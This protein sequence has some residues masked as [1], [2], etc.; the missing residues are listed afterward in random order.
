MK[1]FTL[2]L[3]LTILFSSASF[4]QKGSSYEKAMYYLKEKGEVIFTF[5]ANSKAQFLEINRIVSVSHK[6]V[7]ENELKA[8]VYA[9]KE[10]FQKFLTYGLA[11]EVTAE[12][13]EIPQELTA[14][15]AAAAWDTTWDA[16]P[17]YSE[18]VAKMQ[19]WAATYPSLCT[20]QSIGT[21]ALGRTL[22]VLKISD[23]AST[24]E[25]EPEF[26]YTSSMH[27]DEITGYPTMLH[28]I[29]YLLTNYGSL[30]EI[31][32]LVN[33]T[34]LYINPLANPDG[35]YKTISND[36]YNPG[37]ATNTPTR[38]NSLGVDLNRNYA[39]A[40][41]G[42]HDDG[43]AYQLETVAFMNFQATRNFVLAA[44][45]HGGTEVINFPLDTS[46]T[47]G[48]GNFSYHPH[49]TYFKFVSTEYAQLCQTADGNLNYMDAVYN[50]GQFPGTTNG[51]AWYSV[52]GGRQ[53]ASNYF[54]HSKEITVE[55]SDLKTPAAAN[56][57]FFWDRNRQAL[58]NFVKQANYGLHGI[59]TDQS[60]NPIHAKVYVGGTFDNFGSWVETSPTKGDYH[61]V[62]IAG[63]YNVIFEAPGY[64][65]Q[66]ISV[67]LTNNAT[68]TLNV[69]MVPSTSVPTASDA[70][71]C[72]GQTA[73][74][75]ATGTGTIRW[76]NSATSTTPLASTAAYTT[77]ALTSNTSYWVEREVT[78]ANV[79][80]ATVSGTGATNAALANRYLIFNCTTP[81]KLKSVA[82][83]NTVVG[84]IL[85]ELQNSSGV[86][87]ESKV[88]RLTTTGSKDI[89]LDFFLPVATGLRLVSRQL[90]GTSNTLIRATTGITYPI[91]SGSISITANSGTG[92]FF[93]F[94]N[95]KLG[96]VKS[97]R[98]EVIVTVKPNPTNDSVNPTSR[99]AG[100]GA[101]TLTVNGTNFVS[102]ESIV[103][104]N[105]TNRTTT[106][107]S[108]TQLTAAINA[109]DV[110]TAGTA[111]VT[112]FNTCNSTT[113][114]ART[115]TINVNC[116]APVPNVASLP[117]ITAQCSATVT[118]PT[119]TSNCYGQ[120]TGTTNSP[121]TYN[122]QGTYQIYW[123]YNDGNG[124]TSNQFQT[125]TITDTTAPVAN[126][127]TLPTI[128][129]QCSVNITQTPTATDNC[130]GTINGTTTDPLTY[131]AQGTYSILWTYTDN[132]GNQSFQS[133]SV[134][135][136]DTIAP[137]ANVASLPTL[138]GQCSRTVTA[139]T[140]TD[141]CV[142]TITGTTA[143]P[144]TY[145]AQGTYSIT[146]TYNDGNGNTS[147]QTQT[148]IV[149]DTIAPVANVASLPT[150]T[151]QCSAS[152]TAPTATD[153][154][155][156]TITGTTAS[157]LTYNAQGTYNITWTYNDGNGNTSTQTQTVIVD[158]T[159]API[160]NVASLPTV[161][162]Q[163]SAT[164][165]APTASDACAGTI[166]GTTASPLTY[167]AQGTYNI[168]WTYNDGNG[169]TS[170]QTQTVVVHDTIVPLA[171][172]ASLPTVTGQCSATVT[173]P[174]ASDACAGTITG[175]TA[176]PLTY[177]AQ[178]TYN[179]TWTYNDG[180][181]NTSTQ[182]QTVVVDDTIAPLA[183]VASL[184]TVTGQC[185]ATVTAPTATDACAGTITGTTA[186]PLTYNAQ[187]TFTV[188][189]TYND[190]NGNT[191]T[192]TQT[193]IVDDTIAPIANVA[194]LPTVTGQCSATVTAPTATDACAG[195][196]TGTTTD[197]LTYNAQGT[198]TVTWTYNDGNGN[199]STQTQTVIVDDTIAPIANVASLPTVSGQCSATVTAPSAT[200]A[201]AGTITGTTTDAL[202]YNAQ[203]TFTV[204]WTYNDGNGN[205]STQTQ[206]VVVDDTIAP[207]A[208]VASLPTVT[209]Q[210]SATVTAPTATDACAGIITG[211]TTDALTY[212]A[213]GTYTVTWTYN[214]G[215][216]NT[217]T[218]TQTLIVD[219]TI[220]PVANVASLP[221]VTG[222]CSATVTAPRAT[223]A[224]AG[225]I[226][227]TT[228]DALTYNAQGTYTVTW[229]YN[230]GNGNTSTQTQTIIVD[231]TIAPV[232]NVASLPT[233][234]G[235]CSATVTAPTATDA[236]TGTIT[237]TT[238]DALTYNAQGTYTITWTYNDGNG[239]T[240]TQTQTVIVD[241]T[242][243][244]LANVASLPTVTGQCSATVTAPTATDACT[245]TITGTTTDALT[246]NTQG[247][248]TITWTYNDGNG[249]TSTQTQTV[250]VDDTIAPLANV[251]SLPTVTGQ[252][253]ATVTAPTANDT[254]A[255]TITAT[256]TD[257]L[258]YNA[259]G[260]YTV[261]WTYNDG[262][263]NTSTQTQTVIVDDTV[264]PIANV[265]S[266]P[267]VTGQ[268]SATVT[269]P[270]AT[271]AC[272]GTITGTTTDALTYYAQGTYTVTWTYNDGNGNTS[273]QTQSV[274]VTNGGTIITFYQDTDGDTFGNPAVTTQACTQPVGYVLN[275]T[276]CNDNEIQYLDA[277]NDGF[278][279]TTIVACGV[280]NN[281]DC[282]D[283][284]NTQN[285]LITFYQDIDG[286]TFG[287]LSV[288]TQACTQPVG[289]VLD[290]TDCND[291][292][293]QY[294]DADNDGFGSTTIVACGV[295]NNTDC[296]DNN[297]TQNVLIT[298]YQDI[299]G[300]TFGN[301]SVSTQAC[302]QPVGYV[303]NNS[304][305]N[306][307]Q[308]QYLDADNDGFGSTTIVACG[309]ANNTDCNDNNNTQN[310]LI[311]FYQD[312][313]GDTF[314]NPSV[315]TQACS[316]PV[317]YVLNNS[318]CNDNQI[319]YL[320]ADNDGFGSTTIVDCGV[321]NNIDCNDNN[322]T[323]NVLITFY[324]DID[325]DTFG[326]PSVST[327]ACSQPV[328]YVLNNSD[329][330]DNQI[331]Y[332]D[333]DNDGFGST[334]IV[335]CG[336]AN[337]TDCNDNN[338]TQN[339]LITFYQDL[340]GDTFGN[341]LVSTQACSQ[342]VGYVTNN[343]DC[344]DN[345]A[346][347]NALNTY[348]QDL[349]NDGFGNPNVST[350]SC[351][352][353]LGYV[354]F[355]TDC[356]D[357]RAN[358][359]PNAV[360]VC[361]DGLDND[362]NGIIDNACTP[363]VGSLPSGTCGT[364]IAG[365]YSTVTTN[366][367]NSAQG[368]RFKITKVD[369]NTNAP[370]A[371]PVIIDRPVNNISLANVPGTTYNSRYMFEIAVRYN[372]VWQPFFG[373]PCYLNTPNPVSTIGAQCGSTLTAM[374]QWINAGVV[375]GVT[376]YRFRVTR[377][378]AGVPTGASQEIT[379][380]MNRF[381]MT[382]LS[383]ILFASTYRV[384]VSLRNMDGTFLPYG[385]PCD[386]YTPAHPTTQL[387][388]TFC[389][390]YTVNSNSE[391]ITANAI[392][393][394]T[395]YRFRIFNG[396]GYNAT[397]TN[398]YN[399][400]TLNNF[401]GLTTGTYS[402]QVS[403][404]L[405]NEPDFGPY[406]QTCTIIKPGPV[407]NKTI[408]EDSIGEVEFNVSIYPNPFSDSFN[409]KTNT[410]FNK[411]TSI[412]VYDLTGRQIESINLDSNELESIAIGSSYPSGVYSMI[413]TQGNNTK[414]VRI[415]KR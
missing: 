2:V 314:G 126:V 172:L 397:Y 323:Q 349:D 28:F 91:T 371:A 100:S 310:V 285:V 17:R 274:V 204:T 268:C 219:D 37:G 289:Y 143:S 156:G 223:D 402:V 283:N 170:T 388:S 367:T 51:A 206:T 351:S 214:D 308:I 130:M 42:L 8:E 369:M 271:D 321:A 250:I 342:P 160:A 190:G 279:S 113:T 138:T 136:D 343:L 400:F 200:D 140:A 192:Q 41:G 300:D 260:T 240:S 153:A 47:P 146:W 207:I 79:G 291:N 15:R 330:N 233:V 127:T 155:A 125:V 198:F 188:T 352:Q 109:T 354:I 383:G 93:Q 237:G 139:P 144:L 10:Q 317:G 298:F 305:C 339:V 121:L 197:A 405:P 378:I 313:D 179:I 243:A 210:C 123:T 341:P 337:N 270:T 73:A 261:T 194:S 267:T 129:G 191:S 65:T 220:A 89:D 409:I 281:T 30:S 186:S 128:S 376:A 338:N 32:N 53:D 189:W 247:T 29:D 183:N 118:A 90:S 86:M 103:R 122:A 360:D 226:T 147:T 398:L 328:G 295:A 7:D 407:N 182:T 222:Q 108:S 257:A 221:T 299:D 217:S 327:Q 60:G 255:G 209:G 396:S 66:T 231:D 259:Q 406:G 404:K 14:N 333:A 141:A 176:S 277:D 151:G 401:A 347:S 273:T 286:D 357:T 208:N 227:G 389:N 62:Q 290:N 33:G 55:I 345:N 256:T 412:T 410:I 232:A 391:L 228:T 358:V 36:I 249:N 77:P 84:D 252:C 31:T 318:D 293:I 265:A 97:N 74:L 52:Y 177:N 11:Y 40:I 294:L 22:Y 229:T 395:S 13:N 116:T 244:P 335:A 287:N 27:G 161:T 82:I 6:A 187:G 145:N 133:Q 67:T 306:D 132:R 95:W 258:T 253:S 334:T 275:N 34:E 105:G 359:N 162:G 152:V 264:A 18:Y 85:V 120:I 403:V 148:V 288:S 245:G 87:L 80:P 110:A 68:T 413:V 282:N 414:T 242:I 12:D 239:N 26:F 111:N 340:D 235:Q 320:D 411:N 262:N 119:A 46:N 415:V 312:I 59:V 98:D 149:D 69:T 386:I 251:A 272:A 212:N 134:I 56:L 16:Y 114:S 49:D 309:V 83:N 39:D 131:S 344:N 23:N 157:P 263:G 356:D 326:N 4:A 150:V 304:D 216:G 319:Q 5:K 375:S 408:N 185:S 164:V 399:R 99:L 24:D 236:C 88:V 382:Q 168:T 329:C 215:N 372:N 54:D 142:G 284:N 173:A 205:T 181:G 72:T 102:G 137:V 361:Y 296:N 218:Q 332:L 193:V 43:F 20:L 353:P 167:N 107:V 346:A 57:P 381:N 211:T 311:T 362:C 365:L 163:C 165:T 325:G 135:F 368:Y 199:T 364:T 297:N 124:N 377:V 254:C 387:A 390:N 373:T 112:V 203:G 96:A 241:D 370:I 278:G 175:T 292:E 248:Y 366:W 196:I 316:Q 336:V 322:N 174:T 379:Q 393:G 19:Y 61:K 302:S 324:Q 101:F 184:P 230:D 115:F 315:S 171:N 374:N 355:G 331:Q 71:I 75:S 159:I 158:D 246:Y 280:A 238:T 92:T 276:D 303:L 9:N 64:A 48:T 180:N 213:Q 154:C 307:N 78:P 195:T 269:A 385:T 35:S 301:P 50:T 104:W 166:T 1:K 394:A 234:T 21:T 3:L 384:E 380:G 225:T 392:N 363:I 81:T 44:N 348:Y 201:C 106:F 45:Y 63:T 25:T 202:T 76:Y 169:N 38:A 224:C 266:L 94:F 58:L 350:Q 70:T 117:T 178:G